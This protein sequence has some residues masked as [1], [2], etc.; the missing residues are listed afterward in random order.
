MSPR[1]TLLV[2]LFCGIT[3]AQQLDFGCFSATNDAGVLVTPSV[4][5]YGDD[6]RVYNQKVVSEPSAIAYCYSEQQVHAL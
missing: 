5:Q 3:A 2:A 4:P 1:Y 6:K